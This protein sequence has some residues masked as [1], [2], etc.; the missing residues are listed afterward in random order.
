MKIAWSSPRV[1]L[2]IDRMMRCEAGW[3]YGPIREDKAVDVV[4]AI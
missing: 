1:V 3:H 4:P 2:M